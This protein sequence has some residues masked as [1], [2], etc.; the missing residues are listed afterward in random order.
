MGLANVLVI[1]SGGRE[2]AIVCALLKNPEVDRVFVAPG[3][4]GTSL[5]DRC[6]NVPCKIDDL[7]GILGTIARHNIRLTIIGPEAP[8]V[9]GLAD[10]LRAHE[11]LVFA[12]G[13]A[14]AR[15]EASK[16]VAKEF[17]WRNNIPTAFAHFC[18]CNESA[19]KT[20]ETVTFPIVVKADGLAAGKGVFICQNSAEANTVISNLFVNKT[21]GRAAQSVLIEEYLEGTEASL[22]VVTDGITAVPLLPA[23]DH[24]R[25]L[26]GDRGPNTGGMGAY[27][28]TPDQSWLPET[29]KTI[30][31]PTLSGLA[32]KYISYR[33]IIYFGL[34]LT[35][36]GPKLLEYNCR[37]G[38]PET[39]VVLPLLQSSFYDLCYRAARGELSTLVPLRWSTGACVGVVLT[40]RGYPGPVDTGYSISIRPSGLLETMV[41]HGGT[42]IK[43]GRLVTAGG[44]V[45]TAVGI[46]KNIAV[47]R[48]T[49]YRLAE[50]ITFEGRTYRRDIASV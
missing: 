31:L 48:D 8:I 6:T 42:A 43:E 27:A 30:V 15:L 18:S 17:M 49:A 12:P 2:H 7:T 4:A 25:A 24:K 45:I 11:H 46:G 50:H 36:D 23:R 21:L 35:E 5:M 33:G 13:K 9:A 16:I 34:M 47:A 22:M 14:G 28:P 40:S 44:R 19:H 32:Q 20:L 10:V 3:N 26:E 41:F 1:G 37:F 29:I 39:Q 38:D